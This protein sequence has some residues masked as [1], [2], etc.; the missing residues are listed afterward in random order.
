MAKSRKASRPPK[1][2]DEGRVDHGAQNRVVHEAK[3]DTE[4]VSNTP[5][6]LLTDVDDDYMDLGADDGLREVEDKTRHQPK[7]EAQAG[8]IPEIRVEAGQQ[9]DPGVNPTNPDEDSDIEELPWKAPQARPILRFPQWPEGA[10][11]E[12]LKQYNERKKKEA[13]EK[14]KRKS[15]KHKQGRAHRTFNVSEE[16]AAVNTEISVLLI[17]TQGDMIEIDHPGCIQES[18]ITAGLSQLGAGPSTPQ[19][20]GNHPVKLALLKP[21]ANSE[22]L[23]DCTNHKTDFCADHSEPGQMCLDIYCLGRAWRQELLKAPPMSFLIFDL[24]IPFIKYQGKGK[25]RAKDTDE[26]E[27]Q[28]AWGDCERPCLVVS[29]REVI[30]IATTIATTMKIRGKNST[31]FAVMYDPA[32]L[33]RLDEMIELKK[34]LRALSR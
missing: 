23:A 3:H 33:I 17:Q 22:T 12:E 27:P 20:W 21:L 7:H 14:A 10:T 13:S 30:H 2:K 16:R 19:F 32:Q 28:L 6:V 5:A 8:A 26:T 11:D 4:S 25:A 31:R 24:T 15:N 29:M 1:P 18:L 34:K 9:S